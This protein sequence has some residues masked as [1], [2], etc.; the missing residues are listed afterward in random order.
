M[1]PRSSTQVCR[2]AADH[3][4]NSL[5]RRGRPYLG[6]GVVREPRGAGRTTLIFSPVYPTGAILRIGLIAARFTARL[7]S[8]P[9]WA[10]IRQ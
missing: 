8:A 9:A 1:P 7:Q 10:G 3:Q 6:A 4:P 5:S 2:W